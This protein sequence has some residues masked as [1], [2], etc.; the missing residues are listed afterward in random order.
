MMLKNAVLALALGG[1]LLAADADVDKAR[2]Q[3][4]DKKYDEAITSL[5]ATYKAKPGSSEVKKTLAE[6]YL[7]KG[8]SLMYNEA[9]PPRMKYPGALKAYRQVLQYDKANAKAQ[10]GVATIEGIYKQMGRPV[11][12]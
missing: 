9:L 8:D 4:A 11:P 12:Q 6:A 1:T 7:G 3:I 10:Q 2:K 5:E